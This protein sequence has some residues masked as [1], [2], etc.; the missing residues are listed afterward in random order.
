MAPNSRSGSERCLACSGAR[1][2]CRLTATRPSPCHRLPCGSSQPSVSSPC[3]EGAVSVRGTCQTGTASCC[4]P[5]VARCLPP[6]WRAG[7]WDRRAL[8]EKGLWGRMVVKE[9][10]QLAAPSACLPLRDGRAATLPVS[11][12][13]SRQHGGSVCAGAQPDLAEVP[14]PWWCREVCGF[15]PFLLG[16]CSSLLLIVSLQARLRFPIDYPYSPP[17]FRFLT[18]MWHPNIYEVGCLRQRG[19]FWMGGGG[20]CVHL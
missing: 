20:A 1:L 6:C 18:K 12:L 7:G 3:A 10:P 19:A 16:R 4:T 11:C 2:L 8:L 5:P 13:R 14:F 9:L 17:A 15:L